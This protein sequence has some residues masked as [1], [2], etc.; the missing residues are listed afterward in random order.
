MDGFPI[1]DIFESPLIA[2]ICVA[3]FFAMV[4]CLYGCFRCARRRR[5]IDDTP[6][7]TTLGVFIGLVELN[8]TAESDNPLISFLSETP[9]VWHNWSVE[10]HW[11]RVVVTTSTDAQGRTTTSS[12]TES[13]WKT[14]ASGGEQIP[15]LL[16]DDDGEILVRPQGATIEALHTFSETCSRG[17]GL[18]Y[19]KGP[20]GSVADSTHER[21]FNEEAIPLHTPIY[22]FGQAREREDVV[23]PEIS[24]QPDDPLYLISTRSEQQVSKGYGMCSWG[25]MMLGLGVGLGAWFTAR[26]ARDGVEAWPAYM[27]FVALYFFL[28]VV[29]WVWM[30]FNSLVMLRQR[31][32]QGWSLID[33]QL[34]RRADL[35]PALVATVK[36]YAVHEQKVQE[37]VAAL[38]SQ[39][40]PT[41]QGSAG[42]NPEAV[43]QIVMALAEDYPELKADESFLGLQHQLAETEQRIALARGYFNEIV[44]FYNTRMEVQPDSLVATMFSFE[45]VDFLEA[46]GFERVVPKVQFTEIDPWSAKVDDQGLNL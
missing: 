40:A 10:E 34:K 19:G 33:V 35:I 31:V 30:V 42:E 39:M 11:S 24:H 36:G 7:M 28:V 23:A 21:R 22:L 13:G 43:G 41:P 32:R 38:R 15:F 45:K 12:R 17:A 46:S 14:I 20:A 6:T 37:A 4:G 2:G 5:L 16:R 1:V 9:C 44:K 26:G 29:F 25:L 18:Y 3:L 27:P 8:G